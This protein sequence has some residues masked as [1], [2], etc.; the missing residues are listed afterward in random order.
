VH[1]ICDRRYV[2]FGASSLPFDGAAHR[3]RL[4]IDGQD[5][6]SQVLEL[7]D[8]R[9]DPWWR[10]PGYLIAASLLLAAL[11]ILV[12]WRVSSWRTARVAG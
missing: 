4:V 8:L 11:T 9:P 7:P 10:E 12:G 6:V 5:S 3:F 2:A 1:A